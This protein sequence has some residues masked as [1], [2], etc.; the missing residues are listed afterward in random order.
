MKH[1]LFGRHVWKLKSKETIKSLTT[2]AVEKG[3]KI[4]VQG[5]GLE[6]DRVIYVFECS[7]CGSEKAEVLQ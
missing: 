7:I 2:L 5:F 3:I 1:H 4:T 6:K